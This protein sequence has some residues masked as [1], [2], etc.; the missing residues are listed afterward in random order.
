M[1]PK[2]DKPLFKMLW[3]SKNK[4]VLFRPF[5]VKEEKILLIAQESNSDKDI[6]LAI[7]QILN[8]CIQDPEFKPELLTTFDLEYM[9]LKLRAKSV[10]NIVTLSYEDTEDTKQYDFQV[11]LDKI[12]LIRTEG[13]T[14]VVKV[15]DE[16]GII[17]RYPTIDIMTSLPEDLDAYGLVDYLI[18]NCIEKIYD[19][20]TVYLPEDTTEEDL[21]TF[22]NDL[23]VN[24]YKQISMFFDTMP[25]LEYTI[26][27]T[28][29][30]GSDRSI[31][32]KNLK[33][34]FIWG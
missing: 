30:M 4:E 19:A 25:K 6:T 23:D 28:N 27:Y 18:K 13:H 11:N 21:D 16:V 5:L 10:E 26:N 1:L 12:E 24:T 17:M 34:F 8:N 2:L 31:V 9:F 20:E 3:P 7:K 14:N 22:I 33:D 15:T 29:S 32:L